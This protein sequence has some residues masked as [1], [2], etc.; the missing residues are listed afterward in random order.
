MRKVTKTYYV[1]Q[2]CGYEDSDPDNLRTHE[3]VCRSK[4]DVSELMNKWVIID[5]STFFKLVDV[6]HLTGSVTGIQMS[7]YEISTCSYRVEEVVNKQVDTDD[8][9]LIQWEQWVQAVTGAIE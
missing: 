1:C 2:Y 5:D 4:R 8:L 7:P 3:K 9:H 6:K